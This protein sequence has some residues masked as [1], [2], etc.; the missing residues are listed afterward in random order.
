M[1]PLAEA[2]DGERASV[3]V[4]AAVGVD[5]VELR[6]NFSLSLSLFQLQ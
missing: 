2:H 3:E 6:A 5:E 4:D 1:V